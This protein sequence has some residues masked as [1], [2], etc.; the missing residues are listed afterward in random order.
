MGQETNP[1]DRAIVTGP[2]PPASKIN[3]SVF[4]GSSDGA[5]SDHK[6]GNK[7][8]IRSYYRDLQGHRRSRL[9]N[10]YRDKGGPAGKPG[11]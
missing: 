11:L 6:P 1:R 9:G 8:A 4:A 10:G 7:V 2:M 3:I 5:R